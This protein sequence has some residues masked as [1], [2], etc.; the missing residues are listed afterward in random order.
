MELKDVMEKLGFKSYRAL[1][2]AL[3]KS[4][5]MV[6]YWNKIGRIPLERQAEIR[7]LAKTMKI[8]LGKGKK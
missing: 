7:E 1:A 8:K 6:I 4:H 3:G 2:R 5:T